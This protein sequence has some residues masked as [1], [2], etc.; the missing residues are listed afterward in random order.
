MPYGN[1]YFLSSAS[2]KDNLESWVLYNIL[3]KLICI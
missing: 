3:N 1:M 2:F